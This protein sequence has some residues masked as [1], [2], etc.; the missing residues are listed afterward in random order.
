MKRLVI[1]NCG[2]SCGPYKHEFHK[3]AFT[4][5]G[6]KSDYWCPGEDSNL[7]VLTDTST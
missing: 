1:G 5:K 3:I 6:L 4:I 2:P 7:H